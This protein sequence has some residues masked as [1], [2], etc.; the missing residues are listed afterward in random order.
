MRK[1]KTPIF[2]DHRK[3]YHADSC[4]PLA[5]AVEHGDLQFAALARGTYPG[6]ELPDDILPGLRSVGYWDADHKQKWALPWH[7]NEGIELTW[8]ETGSVS[9]LLG[10]KEYNIRP[11]VSPI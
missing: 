2:R 4:E 5:A 6:T 3:T 11:G 1:S 9:F 7:R 8:L 10:E